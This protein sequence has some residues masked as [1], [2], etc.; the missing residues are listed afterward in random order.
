MVHHHSTNHIAQ[1]EPS[2]TDPLMGIGGTGSENDARIDMEKN[3]VWCAHGEMR[4]NSEGWVGWVYILVDEISCHVYHML[5]ME[6]NVKDKG[7]GNIKITR[8]PFE[9]YMAIMT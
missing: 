1:T 3:E 9:P 6:P 4:N 8:R 2:V 7:S 5:I